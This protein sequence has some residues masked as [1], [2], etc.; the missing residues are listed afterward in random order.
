MVFIC[1]IIGGAVLKIASSVILPFV[2]AV[3]LALVM[4]PL[5]IALDKIRCP[6][7]LS[8][9]LIVIIV[10]TGMFL[11]GTVFFISGSMVAEQILD[12][13]SSLYA[14]RL[15]LIFH[16]A[17]DLFNLETDDAQT[18]WQNLWDQA[19]IR[20]F[21]QNFAISITNASFRFVT[22]A[23]LML[24][25]LV[26]ILMEAS[27]FKMKLFTAFENRI[28]NFDHM[29][30]EIIRQVS[31]YLGAKFL[32]SLANGI[33]YFIGFSLV[34]LQFAMVWAVIQFLLNFIPALGS[35]TAG[36]TIS[37]FA[38]IQFGPEQPGPIIIVV[39]IILA[40][41]LILSNLLDPKIIGNHVGLSPLVILISL[42]LWGYI[43][44][45]TG[46]VIAV[47]MTV[48]IKIICEHIPILEPVSVLIGSRKSVLK[49]KADME[50]AE[51][52][53]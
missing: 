53:P 51:V 33:I 27:C 31:R 2:I 4:F 43:W 47:P 36:V 52:Q 21:V 44:G 1:C 24:I 48:I 50:K 42:S 35:I 41:N 19:V 25:F 7:F 34:G 20:T 16:E 10:I 45:F 23:V 14:G 11:F 15:E 32:F 6:R 38:L 3:L 5:I 26:F 12:N 49:K 30:N 22:S 46:M 17:A 9:L 37:L 18:L 40:V 28:G 8:I 39:A 29:G 13:E